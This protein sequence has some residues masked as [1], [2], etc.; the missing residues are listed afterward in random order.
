MCLRRKTVAG[1]R[2]FS[3][4]VLTVDNMHWSDTV[5]PQSLTPRSSWL[6]SDCLL[7]IPW[8][9]SKS[10]KHLFI[11]SRSTCTNL[12]MCNDDK[13]RKWLNIQFK[14]EWVKLIVLHLDWCKADGLSA[15]FCCLSFLSA[16]YLVPINLLPF[17]LFP[18]P[19]FCVSHCLCHTSFTHV[20]ENDTDQLECVACEPRDLSP[21][22]S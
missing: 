19:F 14:C 22:L 18:T 9:V 21:S 5:W 6:T 11:H 12:Q 3:V 8:F 15:S 1:K 10:V 17:P 2:G 13:D 4:I 20:L 7:L 16:F